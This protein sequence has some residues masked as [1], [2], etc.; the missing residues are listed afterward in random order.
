MSV[1]WSHA[2]DLMN[3]QVMA[4]EGHGRTRHVETPH[5][6]P[7][8]SHVVDRFVESLGEIIHPVT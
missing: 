6:G 1:T 2:Q 4:P 7:F 3:L 8:D 5:S